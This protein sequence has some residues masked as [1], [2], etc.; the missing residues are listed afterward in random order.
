MVVNGLHSEECVG[1][2]RQSTRKRGRERERGG[3]ERERE[4]ERKAEKKTIGN[5]RIRDP[6]TTKGQLI[7]MN[8]RNDVTSVH[9][10]MSIL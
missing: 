8:Q 6:V 3:R 9:K 2:E 5:D 4:R 7:K 1:E 10:T